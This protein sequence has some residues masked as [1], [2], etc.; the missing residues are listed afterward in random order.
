MTPCFSGWLDTLALNQYPKPV[1]FDHI[2][3]PS[4]KGRAAVEDAEDSVLKQLPS[5]WRPL[6]QKRP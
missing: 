5:I 1:G 4:P 2:G 6:D 3:K